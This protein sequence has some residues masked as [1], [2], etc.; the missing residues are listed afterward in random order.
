MADYVAY[1][2]FSLA[3]EMLWNCVSAAGFVALADDNWVT[4][5]RWLQGV[6][7][8]GPYPHVL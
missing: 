7:A 2:G 5:D 8:Y 1:V 3:N 4:T 6:I